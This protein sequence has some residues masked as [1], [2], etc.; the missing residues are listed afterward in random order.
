MLAT[1]NEITEKVIGERR[2][3]ALRDLGARVGDARTAEEACLIA[4]E[5]L[6]VHDR[7]I[8]FVL[9]YLIDE[10]GRKASLAG[11]AGVAVSEEI[12]PRVV[13]LGDRAGAVWPLAEVRRT[14]KM[15]GRDEFE[16]AFSFAP[17]RSLVRPAGYSGYRSHSLQQGK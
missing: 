15:R 3:V 10:D 17:A 7:D 6:K 9:F 2:I 13:N 12:S 16:G 11:A 1:V 4:A 5:T 8:P 14:G